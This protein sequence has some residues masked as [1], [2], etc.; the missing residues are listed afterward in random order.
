MKA[1]VSDS[2]LQ[3]Y[4]A[5]DKAQVKKR[6]TAQK[7][8]RRGQLEDIRAIMATPAGQRF[9]WRLLCQCGLNADLF[10]TNALT[11]ARNSGKRL[12]GLWSQA[13]IADACP[14]RYL[15]MQLLNSKEEANG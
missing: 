15:E 12:I 14:E 11:M 4:D 1:A 5:G 8:A 13:E 3:V 6:D 10:D 7:C 9:M 2:D